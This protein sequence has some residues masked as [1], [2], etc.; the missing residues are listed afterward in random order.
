MKNKNKILNL[1]VPFVAITSLVW[2]ANSVKPPNPPASA[3]EVELA[4]AGTEKAQTA[5]ILARRVT[6]TFLNTDFSWNN[7][8]SPYPESFAH[9]GTDYACNT[10]DPI[11]AVEDGVVSFSNWKKGSESSTGF[12]KVVVLDS[13][14]TLQVYGH[15]SRVFPKEGMKIQRGQIIGECGS[16]GF[17]SGSHLHLQCRH[18]GL[19]VDCSDYSTQRANYREKAMET[20]WET[21]EIDCHNIYEIAKK[22]NVDYFTL[23]HYNP[24]EA[25]ALE[26]KKAESL[27]KI[28]LNPKSKYLNFDWGWL[29]NARAK[30]VK[31]Y[32]FKLNPQNQAVEAR[33][34]V[35]EH[36][37]QYQ[38]T[39]FDSRFT[40]AHKHNIQ[41]SYDV[42]KKIEKDYNCDA[43]L[44]ASIWYSESGTS[45]IPKNS[46]GLFGDSSGSFWRQTG[47]EVS[48]SEMYL[49]GKKACVEMRAKTRNQLTKD[50]T[51]LGLIA[52]SL[53]AYNGRAYGGAW[54]SP[55]V[56]AYLTPNSPTLQCA[57]DGCSQKNTRVNLG[58]LVVY[59]RLKLYS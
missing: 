10:G 24:T 6:Q 35:L 32:A 36:Y 12:G 28:S 54:K 7:N 56:V 55:Y 46:Q 18:E 53:W 33:H 22:H 43:D 21:T 11:Y 19:I 48:D 1:A 39:L 25:G 4:I 29:A 42:L 52:E 17:S 47:R 14:S 8:S 30:D 34:E 31:L 49:M 37:R 40:E 45:R 41:E 5:N 58:T 59:I 13:G 51:D 38:P 20:C 23:I 15:F 16:T 27:G 9:E 3:W 26:L 44:M 57:V 2:L 50:T